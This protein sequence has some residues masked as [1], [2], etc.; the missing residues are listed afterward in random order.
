[1][2]YTLTDF[3]NVT[4]ICYRLF[5]IFGLWHVYDWAVAFPLLYITNFSSTPFMIYANMY[6]IFL[7]VVSMPIFFVSALRIFH[8]KW[9]YLYR[10]DVFTLKQI[11]FSCWFLNTLLYTCSTLA[12][13]V[14]VAILTAIQ[15]GGGTYIRSCHGMSSSHVLKLWYN[16]LS[17]MTHCR[18]HRSVNSATYTRK[19]QQSPDTWPVTVLRFISL[20]IASSY[21]HGDSHCP[22]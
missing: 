3:V 4:S 2:W 1:M 5:Q 13:F 6:C 10:R 11:R 7:A 15:I 12:S 17:I 22:N 20:S 8:L 19:F 9:K 14:V 16:T 18:Y 21:F